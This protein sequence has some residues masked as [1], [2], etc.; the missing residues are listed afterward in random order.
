MV[1][2]INGT[3]KRG[4]GQSYNPQKIFMKNN[5]ITHY[6][7]KKFGEIPQIF[8]VALIHDYDFR[9]NSEKNRFERITALL[10]KIRHYIEN[11][12]DNEIHI[13][14]EFM[15]KSGIYNQDYYEIDKLTNISNFLRSDFKINPLKTLQQIIIEAAN[16]RVNLDSESKSDCLYIAKRQNLLLS[17]SSMVFKRQKP[18]TEEK[19]EYG[20][21]THLL[22]SQRILEKRFKFA[23]DNK[24]S[25]INELENELKM[26]Y[27][28]KNLENSMNK[29]KS[30]FRKAGPPTINS[31]SGTTPQYMEDIRKKNKLLEYIVLQRTKNNFFLDDEKKKYECN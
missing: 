15:I 19:F 18:E 17:Q 8:P 31:E 7:D 14:K 22:Q 12:E 10:Y 3:N 2:K 1:D 4:S 21:Q 20:N 24:Q 30:K 27:Q 6:M 28:K 25:V 29:T 9:N 11:D 5:A 26:V 23:F 16:G 13:I